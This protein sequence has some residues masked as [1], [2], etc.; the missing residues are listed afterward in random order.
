MSFACFRPPVLCGLVRSALVAKRVLCNSEAF[1]KAHAYREEPSR[2][3]KVVS[4]VRAEE[5]W[6]IRLMWFHGVCDVW[7]VT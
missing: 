5:D 3:R 6:P 1:F 2:M 4:F 7:L